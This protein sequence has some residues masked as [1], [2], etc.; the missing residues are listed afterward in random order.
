MN[1]PKRLWN[2][3]SLGLIFLGIGCI[4]WALINLWVQSHYSADD[5]SSYDIPTNYSAELNDDSSYSTPDK[6]L[7]PIYP[8]EGDKIGVLRIPV[9]KREIPIFQGTGTKEL[10][11]GVGHFIQ[12]VL[13]GEEDNSVLSGHRDTVFRKLYILDIGD[14]LLVETAAGIFTYEVNGI[15]IVHSDDKTVIVPT[16]QAI[17]TLTTCYPFNVIGNAPDRYI[18]SANLVNNK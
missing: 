2:R 11:K 12:S 16:N 5:I 3:I 8:E 4:S 1:K 10:K 7:Y 9:L 18:V 17:L 13:P 15:R 6:I 14:Q